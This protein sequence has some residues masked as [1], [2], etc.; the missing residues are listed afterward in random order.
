MKTNIKRVSVVLFALLSLVFGACKYDLVKETTF[1]YNEKK[2]AAD[3]EDFILP[4]ENVTA[5]QGQSKSVTLTWIPVKNAVQYYIYSAP[6][7]YDT[8]SKISET[9]GAETEIVID[10]EPGITKYY[11]VSAVNYYGS[12]SAKSVVVMGTSL[13]VPVITEIEA[14]EEGDAVSVEWWMDNCSDTTYE[15][16]VEFFI[17]T[18]L[19]SS[20]NIKYKT[21]KVLGSSRRI[22][23]DGLVSKTEYLFEVE[24]VNNQ[25]GQKETSGKCSAETAHRVLPDPPL[26]F[27]VTQGT[28]T[29]EILLSWK[30]P[31]GAWYRENSG[32]SGFVK[33]PLYFEVYKKEAGKNEDYTS[34]G[35]IAVTPNDSWSHRKTQFGNLSTYTIENSQEKLD[36]PYDSYYVGAQITFADTIS[37]LDRG[38]KFSYYVQSVTDDTPDGKKITSQSSCTLGTEGWTVAVPAFT[39]KS[40]YET[41]GNYFTKVSFTYNLKFDNYGVPYS[42]FVKREQLSFEGNPVETEWVV[43]NSV[44]SLNSKVDEF[45]P[46]EDSP[47]NGYYKYTLYVCHL[48]TVQS[49]DQEPG[50]KF[51]KVE[52]SGK[53]IVTHDATKIPEIRDFTVEDGYADRFELSWEYNSEYVYTIH[54]WEM[55][56]S[57]KGSEETLEITAGEGW[58]NGNEVTYSHPT[59]SGS[60][61][62]YQLEASTG[63]SS[64]A[65][66]TDE[67]TEEEIVFETLGTPKPVFEVYD[68]NT[69]TVTWPKVQQVKADGEYSVSAKYED[70]G[71][72]VVT[73]S[74]TIIQ[75]VASDDDT[76]QCVITNP[77]GWNDASIS[78]K[79]INLVVTAKNGTKGTTH[80]QPIAVCTLG[81]ALANLKVAQTVENDKIT[82]QW[83]KID[84]AA[85]Y[86][87]IRQKFNDG[88]GTDYDEQSG[89]DIY[90]IKGNSININGEPADS[91]HATIRDNGNGTFLFEDKSVDASD[92]TNPYSVNQACIEWGLPFSY[93]IVPLK[94]GSDKN[95]TDYVN[96]QV[97]LGATKG[98]GLNVHAEKSVSGTKQV[99]TW[100]APYYYNSNEKPSVYYRE[101]GNIQNKWTKIDADFSDDKKTASV[102]PDSNVEAYEYLI[103]YKRTSSMLDGIVP[104]SL[105]NDNQIGL[106]VMENTEK[107]NKGYL[108]AVNL[109][110]RTGNGY[111]EIISWDE[112]DYDKRAVG[113]DSAYISIINYNLSNQGSKVVTLDSDLH[114]SSKET[115]TETV[116]DPSIGEFEIYPTFAQPGST[117]Q[118]ETKGPLQILR[119]AKHYYYITLERQGQ[120]A[121]ELYKNKTVYAYRN[122]S[123]LELVKCALLQMSYGF[124]LDCGGDKELTKIN[125]RLKYP[126][127][128]K[129]ITDGNG[130]ASFTTTS[131]LWIPA[132]K[133]EASVTMS[134][135]AYQQLNPG[136][137]YTSVVKLS[138]SN[139]YFRLR[140]LSD[141]YVDLFRTE[142]FTINVRPVDSK[143]PSSYS[144]DLTMKCTGQNNLTVTNGSFT[145]SASSIN[146]RRKYLPLQMDDDGHY[147]LKDTGL[148]WWPA[149]N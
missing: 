139:V 126:D 6:T 44:E 86:K 119:D 106:S 99:I 90:Y 40:N 34:I 13:A 109:K 93:Q 16:S 55:H 77:S 62:I 66:I 98:Y 110:A 92:P 5:S 148:G 31:D 38:K 103:A 39:I 27:T 24:V 146:E 89:R 127:S 57:E 69:I 111:S 101:A 115:L 88:E 67:N 96:P 143:M 123:P 97:K 12:V 17:Y 58:Q 22:K 145:V 33:H 116:I 124:Y 134:N 129:T 30:T 9:K 50:S 65:K 149:E 100:N 141:S 54:W 11:C 107:A 108:L 136:G 76:W 94:E 26:D 21:E 29:S 125:D 28:S 133:Y 78:G 68:Y 122:I 118:K 121:V 102:T 83:N 59:L 60:R 15:D 75:P 130:S 61:R 112:W 35:L 36:S 70:G 1:D 91:D 135:F 85:G 52:A 87:I 23:I 95:D 128:N 72:E 71:A 49:G 120:S 56:G 46:E 81:P 7:P 84:G 74:N 113:P 10:E 25:T 48:G 8:F 142:N 20:P 104:N 37:E 140:G 73:E 14:S 18:S 105:I 82:V 32:A 79:K 114:Y 43:F 147:W 144:A 63:I 117:L 47:Q 80:S 45:L 132:G 19:K 51:Y 3:Y 131:Y 138:M 4:P 41:E 137:T 2:N 53:Y 42:Y 64:F